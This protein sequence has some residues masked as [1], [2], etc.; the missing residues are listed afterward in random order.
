MICVNCEKEMP[1]GLEQCPHC[2]CH[3]PEVRRQNQPKSD[4][5]RPKPNDISTL[6]AEKQM[7]ELIDAIA[8]KGFTTDKE[9]QVVLRIAQNG[10]LDSDVV[11]IKLDAA[12][13]KVQQQKDKGSKKGGDAIQPSSGTANKMAPVA[14]QGSTSS[15]KKTKGASTIIEKARESI[16]PSQELKPESASPISVV[17]DK[18]IARF[19]K[20][21]GFKLSPGALFCKKC[22]TKIS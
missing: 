7:N 12:L 13:A 5:H 8:I 21:C 22:G 6:S 19:C 14:N 17:E 10:G 15:T 4:E 18:P 9:R 11:E 2:G 1:D 20:K 3:Y 16:Q